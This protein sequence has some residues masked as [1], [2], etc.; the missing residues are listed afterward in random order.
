M[1]RCSTPRLL[2]EVY[3]RADRRRQAQLILVE[4]AARAGASGEPSIAI[5]ARPQPLAAA[6]HRGASATAHVRLRCDARRERDLAASIS[7][8]AERDREP[9]PPDH[10]LQ[11]VAGLAALCLRLRH[12]LLI[13]RDEIDRIEQQRREAAV[14][15]RRARRSRARTET[16]AA[17]IRS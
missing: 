9:E 6:A 16:T 8:L 3:R 17:G 15:H 14:A 2:A 12:A 4:A 11:P 5:R 13:E 1:A 7:V 10:A